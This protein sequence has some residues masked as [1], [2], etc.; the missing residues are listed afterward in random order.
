MTSSSASRKSSAGWKQAPPPMPGADDEP[1]L[2][3]PAPPARP[4]RPPEPA[5][6]P[7]PPAPVTPATR[8]FPDPPASTLRFG[9]HVLRDERVAVARTARFDV[10]L[11]KRQP[12]PAEQMAEWRAEAEAAGYAA[13]WAQGRREAQAA[14]IAQAD[15]DAQAVEDVMAATVQQIEQIMHTVARAATGLEQRMVPAVQDI[16]NMI[17]E[18]ALAIAESILGRELAVSKDPG[19]EAIARALALAPE[20]RPVTVRLNPMDRMTIGLSDGTTEMVMDGRTITLVDDRSLKPGDV[21]AVC[22][23]TTIDARLGPA[24]DRV[25]EVLGL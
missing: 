16:E 15:K 24:L 18:T 11:R 7:P 8:A 22:D 1:P 4:V 23:A 25:R 21:V 3:F 2:A 5:F 10:D 13:G 17:A 14:A 19:R 20:Q 9:E 6:P 12:P